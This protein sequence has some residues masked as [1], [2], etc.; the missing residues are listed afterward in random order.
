LI[1]PFKIKAG[2]AMLCK[3]VSVQ[4]TKQNK[5]LPPDFFYYHCP[6]D[7]FSNEK[8]FGSDPNGFSDYYLILRYRSG[9]R[10]GGLQGTN[11]FANCA[12]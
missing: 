3:E 5:E 10:G 4:T 11:N 8:I 12:R 1:S 2:E 7:V 6:D 9:V